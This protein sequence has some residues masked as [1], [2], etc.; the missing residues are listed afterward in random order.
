MAGTPGAPGVYLIAARKDS[1]LGWVIPEQ[2]STGMI[3]I[4]SA[5]DQPL[6]LPAGS[7]VDKVLDSQF[8]PYGP[9]RLVPRSRRVCANL[10]T[11]GE[12]GKSSQPLHDYHLGSVAGDEGPAPKGPEG[13]HQ[14]EDDSRSG[15]GPKEAFSPTH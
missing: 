7:A 8:V 10:L 4:Q 12:T 3:E 15:A 13:F 6:Y 9:P 5:A 1:R 11:A 14:E 2:L